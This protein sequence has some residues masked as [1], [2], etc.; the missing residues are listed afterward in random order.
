M[1]ETALKGAGVQTELSGYADAI[2]NAIMAKLKGKVTP[3]IIVDVLVTLSKTTKTEKYNYTGETLEYTTYNTPW[4][5]VVS[6]KTN[7][8]DK[9]VSETVYNE[10]GS[11][12]EKINAGSSDKA[13]EIGSEVTSSTAGNRFFTVS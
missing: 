12:S 3:N 11:V 10:K 1:V 2:R 4:K 6:L 5:F 7:N 13:L 9:E 8:G